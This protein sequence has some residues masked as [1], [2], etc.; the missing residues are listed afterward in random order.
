MIIYF[1]VNIFNQYGFK[2][3]NLNEDH[4]AQQKS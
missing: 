1:S 3:S 2:N 4:L